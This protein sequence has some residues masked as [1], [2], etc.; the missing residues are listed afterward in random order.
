MLLIV[1]TPI[2]NLQ[3][4]TL[5]A[6][7]ALRAAEVIAAEDTRAA[8]VL[9]AR[10]GIA[11]PRL[12]S[13]FEGNEVRRVP[14]LLRELEKG[15]TM[16]LISKA[17]TPLIGDPGFRLVRAALA[18]GIEV[19]ALPGP[20]AVTT[21]LAA[22]GLPPE[23]FVFL[24]WAPRKAGRRR[25]WLAPYA[26]LAATLVLFDSPHR[27]AA[28]LEACLEVLGD[29]PAAVGRELTKLHGETLRAPLSELLARFR[30]VEPRGEVTLLVQGRTRKQPGSGQTAAGRP[31]G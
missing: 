29:R 24:G 16:A 4:I 31:G 17:G 5:R 9:L 15:I 7:E 14:Q 11:P 19:E 21:A 3:D 8:R 1:P 23:P 26:E 22:S 6:L 18:A 12:L 25:T 2:G 30:N 20:S 27:L 10:H 28:T 13:F